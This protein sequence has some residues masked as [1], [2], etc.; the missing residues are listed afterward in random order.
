MRFLDNE[1]IGLL[2]DAGGA[3][4]GP[5]ICSAVMVSSTGTQLGAKAQN[6]MIDPGWA[7]G[8]TRAGA[9]MT[10]DPAFMMTLSIAG[11]IGP[12]ESPSDDGARAAGVA[13]VIG[14]VE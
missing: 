7:M 9:A 4:V 14:P 6:G 8:L 5:D 10:N 2:V 1:R 13:G 3:A 12:V 11:V